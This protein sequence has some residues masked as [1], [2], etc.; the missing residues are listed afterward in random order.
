MYRS[1][2]KL[3]DYWE[4]AGSGTT[5]PTYGVM[6][7]RSPLSRN[8]RFL[9]LLAICLLAWHHYSTTSP[10]EEERD[11]FVD[12]QIQEAY[13]QDRNEQQKS[14]YQEAVRILEEAKQAIEEKKA[15]AVEAVEAVKAAPLLKER[16]SRTPITALRERRR[17]HSSLCR[18]RNDPERSRVGQS[19]KTRFQR[20]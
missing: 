19:E 18:G 20:E 12:S 13:P 14:M 10:F 16:S 6:Y 1:S 11:T 4:R 2:A 9:I 7:R 15:E 5:T 17:G 3:P 8:Y